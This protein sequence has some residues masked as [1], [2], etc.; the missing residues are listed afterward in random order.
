MNQIT[1]GKKIEMQI[2]KDIYVITIK[3]ETMDDRRG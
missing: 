3:R 2:E 1:K